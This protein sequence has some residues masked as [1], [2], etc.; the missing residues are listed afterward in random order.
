M[1]YD[2]IACPLC[3]SQNTESVYYVEN[4]FFT[5]GRTSM[6]LEVS[7]CDECGFVFQSSAYSDE[8]DKKVASI[9]SNYR[10][11]DNFSFPR[12]DKKTLESL[13]FICSNIQLDGGSNILEIGSDRGDF[14]YL[15]K[16]RV[17]ANVI[18]MEPSTEQVAMIPTVR[19]YFDQNSFCSK[20]DLIVLKHTLEHIKYP[21]KILQNAIESLNDEGYLYIEVPSLDICME[22]YLD[23]FSL[24]HVSYFSKHVL[25]NL[26]N[27][28]EVVAIDNSHFLRIIVKKMRI[29]SALKHIKVE[30]EKT[31]IF[32]KEFEAR[33]VALEDKIIHHTTEGGI[34]VFYGVG[35]YFRI[36]FARLN[37]S[38]GRENCYFYDDGYVGEYEDSFGLKKINMQFIANQKVIAIWCSNDYAVQDAMA[39]RFNS[40]T[41]EYEPIYFCRTNLTTM[42]GD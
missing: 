30:N 15:L 5:D 27:E 22:H 10:M 35:L 4:M 41:K 13:E 29:S 1:V 39:E 17:G 16:Q 14:L 3:L 23:D 24:D 37:G 7:L 33:F 34:A 38:V 20:F 19:G 36:I 9:Y 21:Q 25:L 26:L 42:D 40:V 8:Y 32:F 28:Y 2:L 12:Q 18:G 11:S 31:R 6:N